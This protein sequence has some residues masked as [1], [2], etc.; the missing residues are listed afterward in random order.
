MILTIS[1][2]DHVRGISV[3]MFFSSSKENM[4]SPSLSSPSYPNPLDQVSF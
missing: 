3:F 2:D 1:K 4:A